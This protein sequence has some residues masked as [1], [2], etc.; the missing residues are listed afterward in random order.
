MIIN[1]NGSN[2]MFDWK[3]D[4]YDFT[5][6]ATKSNSNLI[7]NQNEIKKQTDLNQTFVEMVNSENKE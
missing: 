1:E 2:Y 7:L 3:M 4:F 5:Y 6:L